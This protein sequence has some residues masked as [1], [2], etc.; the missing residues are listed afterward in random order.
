MTPCCV[1]PSPT[2]PLARPSRTCHTVVAEEIHGSAG[3]A[4]RTT[5]G[6]RV[7]VAKL[8]NCGSPRTVQEGRY[9]ALQ[10][11]CHIFLRFVFP[12]RPSPRWLTLRFPSDT[13]AR[14]AALFYSRD[15][16]RGTCHHVFLFHLASNPFHFSP[17][18][19]PHRPRGERKFLCIS[20]RGEA[21]RTRGCGEGVILSLHAGRC[22]AGRVFR[23]PKPEKLCTQRRMRAE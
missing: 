12:L 3:E 11:W 21:M 15:E 23:V 10:R 14:D 4:K 2:P 9:N 1:D 19:L 16:Q 5:G 20:E 13:A 18:L 7:S 17:S 6:C 22:L 8:S